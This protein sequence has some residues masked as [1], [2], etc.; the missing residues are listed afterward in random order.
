MLFLNGSSKSSDTHQVE[1]LFAKFSIGVQ[2][3]DACI[4][5]TEDFNAYD[6]NQRLNEINRRYQPLKVGSQRT[7]TSVCWLPTY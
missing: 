2:Y 4:L 1:F 6:G 3:F 7:H 5:G